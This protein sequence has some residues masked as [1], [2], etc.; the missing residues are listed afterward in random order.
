MSPIPFWLGGKWHSDAHCHLSSTSHRLSLL[1]TAAGAQNVCLNFSDCDVAVQLHFA[2][3]R[4]EAGYVL[5]PAEMNAFVAGDASSRDS[6]R[7]SARG[8]ARPSDRGSAH[9]S[10]GGSARA[11]DRDLA[12]T[13]GRDSVRQSGR[14]SAHPSARDSTGAPRQHF[15]APCEDSA[16][17]TGSD[18]S[19]APRASFVAPCGDQSSVTDAP[20]EKTSL[21]A[22]LGLSSESLVI[23]EDQ[24]VN[25]LA[26]DENV[27]WPPPRDLLHCA[28]VHVISLHN[29]P[30][31][32][33]HKGTGK[34]HT[35]SRTH[36]L[37]NSHLVESVPS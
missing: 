9:P 1:L 2:L 31:V 27:F 16:Q 17:H 33:S 19:C 28:T 13:S 10:D 7:P 20:A 35:T 25:R 29:L 21:L 37:L 12:S 36:T 6:A 15:V 4:G 5:K 32:R 30:K 8:S 14:I 24:G 18:D 22:K 11:S 26:D 3:F 23:D 34:L